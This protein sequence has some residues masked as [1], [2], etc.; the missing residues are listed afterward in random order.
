MFKL[1]VIIIKQNKQVANKIDLQCICIIIIIIII[2]FVKT[3]RL[4]H[5]FILE[6]RFKMDQ[7]NHMPQNDCF[8]NVK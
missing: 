3:R 7:W 4:A 8:R 1:I 5:I 6:S 2:I